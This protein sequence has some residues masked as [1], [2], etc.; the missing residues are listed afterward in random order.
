[1]N[2]QLRKNKAILKLQY[3]S[4]IKNV[5][6]NPAARNPLYN[7]WCEAMDFDFSNLSF[8]P[9]NNLG[10]TVVHPAISNHIKNMCKIATIAI[11][12]LIK[13]STF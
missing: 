11:T 6:I 5:Q 9:P 7:P 8:D 12:I 10:A 2:T 1:M 4:E 13:I 3:G